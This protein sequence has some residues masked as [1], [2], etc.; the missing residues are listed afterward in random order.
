MSILKLNNKIITL[1]GSVV[2]YTPPL[3]TKGELINMNLDGNGNK[4]YRVL[5]CN[6]KVAEVVG[7]N[8]ISNTAQ[9]WDED[10]TTTTIGSLTVAKYAD[11]D[12]DIFLNTTWYDTLSN[13]AKNAI[14]SQT[15]TQDAWYQSAEGSPV[16]TGISG[17]NSANESEYSISKYSDG[18][19]DVGSR[20]I[21][22]LSAQDV[23]DYLSDENVRVDKT[24]I[25]RN[26]N[27][28]K[29]F[30]NT[31]TMPYQEQLDNAYAFWLRS[32]AAS[33]ARK[34]AYTVSS[35]GGVLMPCATNNSTEGFQ[36]L[37][38]PAF[39]INLSKI[40]FTKTTEVIS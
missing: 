28:W 29:M 30:W 21:Y 18:V 3:A 38:R 14:V 17:R 19:I 5:K 25:L 34:Y 32:A 15:I 24:M 22:A 35:W 8:P 13:I 11:S 23:I 26:I 31:E 33:V 1:G 27:I 20:N 36:K 39:Q 40:P 6:G 2:N 10:N 9:C 12:L 4:T 37:V 16:Y 7:M